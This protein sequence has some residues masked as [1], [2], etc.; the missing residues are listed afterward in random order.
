LHHNLQCA[1]LELMSDENIQNEEKIMQDYEL[2]LHL[3][4]TLEDKTEGV[5]EGIKAI[6]T[7]TDGTVTGESTPVLIPLAYQM[8]KK[9]DSKNYKYNTASFGWVKFSTSTAAIESLKEELDLHNDILRYIL[10]KTTADANTSSE[11]ISKF[12]QGDEEDEV[13][14][15]KE[16]VAQHEDKGKEFSEEEEEVKEE[17]EESPKETEEEINQK[18]DEA[19]D[20]ITEEKEEK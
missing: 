18:V 19:I 3:I 17:T 2:G 6:V 13:R 12:L 16:S 7:K 20:A 14:E 4:P 9:I 11:D 5:F 15:E 8:V 10:L 1:I